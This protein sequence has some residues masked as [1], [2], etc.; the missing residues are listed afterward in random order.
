[1]HINLIYKVEQ[2]SASPVSLWLML[3]VAIG[4]VLFLVVFWIFMFFLG[5]RALTLQVNALDT[6]WKIA[7]PKYKAAIQVRTDLAQRTDTLKALQGWRDARI[8]WGQQL[9]Y[10]EKIVPDVI[11]LSD[12]R[13]SHTVMVVSNKMPGR[14]FEVKIS[15]RTA[16]ERSEVNVV[17]FLD[18]FKV[19]PFN[20]FVESAVLPS[21]AFRQDPA[22]KTDRIFEVVGKFYPRL[23]E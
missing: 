3:R 17:K 4:A 15:G 2:R 23:I 22:V 20:R 12:I 8:S 10:L 6:E 14:V 9:G 11:Q 21:G 18:G 16:A 19:E 1:M 13:V 7:E 5:Y